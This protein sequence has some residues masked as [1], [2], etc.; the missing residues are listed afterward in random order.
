MSTTDS[1]ADPGRDGDP[2]IDELRRLLSAA[3]E[4]I[5]I[6][7][8]MVDRVRTPRSATLRPPRPR[9]VPIT[10]AVGI[11][12]VL[13]AG[14]AAGALWERQQY[15]SSVVAAGD[16][17]VELRVAGPGV[18]G[19]GPGIGS[20]CGIGSS[21]NNNVTTCI[22]IDNNGLKINSIVASATVK[23]STRTLR[24]CLR[25]PASTVG[26]TQFQSVPAG[27]IL[28]LTWSPLSNEPPGQYC[29]NTV[30][31]GSDGSQPAIGSYCVQVHA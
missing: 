5:T 22:S 9:W 7:P 11:I 21:T 14:F 27:Y 6:P 23:T 1:E 18:S 4:T 24:E 13:A 29:A 2:A 20:R 26:C 15:P 3:E 28:S 19:A 16:V 31:L 8:G 17:S 25:G 10:A 12:V 30:R